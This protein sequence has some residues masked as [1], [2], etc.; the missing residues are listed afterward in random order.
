MMSLVPQI[1]EIWKT[2]K[3]E[4]ETIG[5]ELMEQITTHHDTEIEKGPDKSTLDDAYEKMFLRFDHE[6]GGFGVAPKFP[7]PHNL[8]FLL[9][10]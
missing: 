6:N 10:Y 1:G 3:T 4:M 8:L 9:R 5:K 7:S 2:R